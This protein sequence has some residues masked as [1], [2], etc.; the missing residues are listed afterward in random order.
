MKGWS[1]SIIFSDKVIDC[2]GHNYVLDAIAGLELPS[3]WSEITGNSI[4]KSFLVSR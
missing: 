3:E 1:I 2:G 4:G